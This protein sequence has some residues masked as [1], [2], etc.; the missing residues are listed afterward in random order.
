[1]KAEACRR[2][3][4]LA[5]NLEGKATWIER[6]VYWDDLAVKA[7]KREKQQPPR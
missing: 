5:E 3:A 6:S 2:L 4:D 1:M 7:A